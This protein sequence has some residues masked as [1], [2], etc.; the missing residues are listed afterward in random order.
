VLQQRVWM[1]R[2]V[3]LAAI[4]IAALCALSAC[5]TPEAAQPTAKVSDMFATPEWAKG[6]QAR[7]RTTRAIT[8]NDLI[9]PD[10]SCAFAASTDGVA[11]VPADTGDALA[12]QGPLPAVQSGVALG[13]TECQILQRTGAPDTFNISAEGTER[14][15]TLTVRGGSWPGLY[16]FRGGRLVSIE[17]VEV[18]VAAKP[19]RSSRSKKASA[20]SQP[21]PLRGAQQ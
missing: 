17:R 10:G 15:A 21:M 7:A 3:L 6:N 12:G 4:P 9:N 20:K 18:P 19:T 1:P 16:R 13:M 14:V 8:Q 11:P 2:T 5:A